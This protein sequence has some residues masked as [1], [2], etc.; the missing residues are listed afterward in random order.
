MAKAI[1]MNGGCT[2]L[3]GIGVISVGREGSEVKTECGE[4]MMIQYMAHRFKG[5]LKL[6][7]FQESTQLY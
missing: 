2:E 5:L 7:V 6:E 1:R 4:G 3:S